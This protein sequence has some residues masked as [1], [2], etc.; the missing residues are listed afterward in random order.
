MGLETLAIV[1]TR[2]CEIYLGLPKRKW[3]ES[4]DKVLCKQLMD[5]IMACGNFGNIRAKN[6]SVTENVFYAAKSPK[7][8][9]SLLQER[10]EENWTAARKHAVLKPLA[11]LYQAFRYLF[12]GFG[13]G[14]DLPDTL[15]EYKAAKKRNEMFKALGVR[16]VSKG[17]VVY[18]NGK[19]IKT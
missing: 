9:F 18:K 5:Y 19:Y 17:L 13:A 2:M 3:C 7:R 15:D 4:G 16:Q 12:M 10:G 14:K 1:T 11:W 8:L 6:I